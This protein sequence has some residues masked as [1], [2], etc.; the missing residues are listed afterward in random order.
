MEKY[1]KIGNIGEGAYAMV[2]KCRNKQT[3][4]VVAIKKFFDTEDDERIR[5]V[6]LR[7]V[8]MLKVH[9]LWDICIEISFPSIVLLLYT[10]PA[11][12]T[13]LLFL[14]ATRP[15]RMTKCF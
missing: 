3:G 5:K 7:E 15:I 14:N 1:E 13:S 4:E 6:A 12:V 11:N 8:K 10:G 9:Y 2:T